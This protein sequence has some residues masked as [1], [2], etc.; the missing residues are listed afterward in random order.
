MLR[1]SNPKC[2]SRHE[3]TPMFDINVT[4]YE[5]RDVDTTLRKVEAR[6]FKCV[7]CFD[8]AEEAEEDGE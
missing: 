3:E 4:V 2:E 8:E 6:F 7:Y 1:C 5:D